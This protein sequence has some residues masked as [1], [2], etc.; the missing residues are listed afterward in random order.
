MA[1]LKKSLQFTGKVKEL[2]F[3]HINYAEL[4]IPSEGAKFKL[5]AENQEATALLYSSLLSNFYERSE[6]KSNIIKDDQ[7]ESQVSTRGVSSMKG[8]HIEADAAFDII[9]YDVSG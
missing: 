1:W 5:I 8:R 7:S 3:K 4:V 9:F 6:R 2:E